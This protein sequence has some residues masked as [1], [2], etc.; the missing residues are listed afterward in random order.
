[1]CSLSTLPETNIF[2][3]KKWMFGIRSFPFWGWPIFRCK[4]LV[5][6]CVTNHCLKKKP[7]VIVRC[8]QPQLHQWLHIHLSCSS[9]LLRMPRNDFRLPRLRRQKSDPRTSDGAFPWRSLSRQCAGKFLYTVCT[10]S[11]KYVKC[12]YY[13]NL[14]I[15]IHVYIILIYIYI[16]V[17]MYI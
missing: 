9:H 11:V 7:L 17:N 12:N 13:K 16:L 10:K 3:P 14:H 15:H 1:M 2:S 5:S 8:Y 4:L 6:G